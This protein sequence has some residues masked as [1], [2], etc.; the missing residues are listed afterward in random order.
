MEHARLKV[1][2]VF[3]HAHSRIYENTNM[4]SNDTSRLTQTKDFP[5]IRTL[6][7]KENN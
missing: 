4:L 2:A 6:L 7:K 1:T 3:E 5:L